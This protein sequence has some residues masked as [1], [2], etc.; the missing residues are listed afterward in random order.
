MSLRLGAILHLH[1]YAWRTRRLRERFAAV[2]SAN[3]G[4]LSP[5]PVVIGAATASSA[6]KPA[7]LWRTLT[8][9]TSEWN[10]L[11]LAAVLSIVAY[12]WYASR[13]L[14]MIYTDAVSHMMIARR[15]VDGRALGIAQLGTVWLPLQHLLMLPLIWITPLF[16]DGFAGS[17]PSMAAYVIASVYLY[18][19]GLFLFSSRLAGW[20]AALTF[21]LNPSMLYMQ[22][23]AMSEADMLCA[24]I[25]AVYY[26]LRWSH[27]YSVNNRT[28]AVIDLAKASIAIAAGT[29]IRYDAW[30]LAIAAAML[31]LYTTWR[32]QG[33]K[34][35]E[36]WIILFAGLAFAG[37]AAWFLFNWL[38]FRDPLAFYHNA[39]SALAQQARF[40]TVSGLPTHRNLFLSVVVYAQAAIDTVGWPLAVLAL[41][42]FVSWLF[43]FRPRMT[44]LPVY[45]VFAPF[46][47]NVL[48]LLT[49][50]SVL[51]TPEIRFGGVSTYF[52][53]RYG[54]MMLPAFAIFLAFL[55]I[56]RRTLLALALG[57]IV[58]FGISY[59][60]VQAPY[61]LE[62]PMT[63]VVAHDCTQRRQEAHWLAAHYYGG[64]ILISYAPD[65]PTMFYSDLPEGVFV[66]DTNGATFRATL[67]QPQDAVSWIVMSPDVGNPIWA[68]L[69]KQAN[70]RRHFVL[71]QTF[72]ATQIYERVG[73]VP[74]AGNISGSR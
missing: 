73:S 71:R 30:F 38:I 4:Q 53:E 13:G 63:G 54:M 72:G 11:C 31:V 70:W 41:I 69:T 8:V 25:L 21:M 59:S 16:R 19:T 58:V 52:N 42:G 32:K 5:K 35:A 48:S 37:C 12:G 44:S 40:Q 39:Y 50:A 49:G 45:L 62:D 7:K 23:T 36:A 3:P 28:Q 9:R 20:M 47:F 33:R 6:I 65:A 10:V 14:T 51:E 74:T 57:T 55:A 64:H 17:F 27:A 68:A 56:H 67:A 26:L 1:R 2:V 60:S 29:L 66:T 22:A 61:A 46:A 18:R 43:Y 34:V 24:A 15:V